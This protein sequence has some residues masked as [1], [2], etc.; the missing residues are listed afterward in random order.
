ME[1]LSS[2]TAAE[3]LLWQAFYRDYGFDPDRLEWASANAGAAAARAMGSSVKPAE[4][5]PTFKRPPG[6]SGAAIMAFF[7]G[8]VDPASAAEAGG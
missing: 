2:I 3:L 6:S 7:D 5:V 1:L 8:L 4:L